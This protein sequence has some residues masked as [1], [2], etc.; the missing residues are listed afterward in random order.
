M[1][2]RSAI[3]AGLAAAGSALLAASLPSSAQLAAQWT[4]LFDGTNLDNWNR[5]GDAN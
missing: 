1:L 4:T 3:L 5:T 2:R